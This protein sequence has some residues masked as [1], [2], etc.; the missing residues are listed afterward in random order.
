MKKLIVNLTAILAF[1]I[2]LPAMAQD[3][4][5]ES[6]DVSGSI[7]DGNKYLKKKEYARA[8]THWQ[9]VIKADPENANAQFKAGLC[10]YNSADRKREALPYFKA[11][12]NSMSEDYSFFSQKERN[13]PYDA[14]Y[15]L[16]ETYLADNKPDSALDN[17]LLYKKSA[18]GEFPIDVDRQILMCVNAKE[19]KRKPR[20]VTLQDMGKEVNTE[21]I[22]SNPV[23]TIDNTILFY[24]ARRP[25][26]E[27]DAVD[28]ATGLHDADIYMTAFNKM[29][30]WNKPKRFKV[31]TDADEAPLCLSADGL[32]LYYKRTDNGVSNL[33]YSAYVDG[34]WSDG[35]KMSGNVNSPFN[36]VGMSIS[37]DGKFL[38]LTSDRPGGYGGYDLYVCV[39]NESGKWGKAQNAGSEVNTA[40]DETSPFIHPNGNSLFF[41]SDGFS[42]MGMGGKDIYFSEK[43]EDGNWGTPNNMGYPINTTGD[44]QHYYITEGGTRYYASLSE[45]RSYDLFRIR[46][47]G[48]AIENVD[49][50]TEVVTLTQ[51]MGV[52]EVLEVIEE[53]E[54]EIEVVEM[55]ETEVAVETEVEVVDLTALEDIEMSEEEKT[56]LALAEAEIKKAEAEKAQ[57]E[58]EIKKAEAEIAAAERA[59]AEAEIKAAEA[60][61]AAAERPRRMLKQKLLKLRSKKLMQ[62]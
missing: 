42:S 46:G 55:I 58:A 5:S 48:Y 36:E 21:Y 16:G 9:E 47:G 3:N 38:Y 2:A 20:D 13:A 49:A 40:H 33:Y 26:G 12:A 30:K 43:G 10:L 61:I 14:L 8:I 18:T 35:K 19:S 11:A 54:K 27:G 59:K 29:K 57:A 45:E 39:L 60:E 6:T 4:A 41:S 52:T 34:V 17:F 37:G 56:E 62:R 31:S 51:E 22:E 50:G 24:S 7:A 28:P 32:T 44:D 15:F 25:H 1:I 53:I 23:L